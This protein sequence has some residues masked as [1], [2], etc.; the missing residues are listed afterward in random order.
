MLD[1][2]ELPW[3]GLGC[4][5]ARKELSPWLTCARFLILCPRT[6]SC[7]SWRENS[8]SSADCRCYAVRQRP[9]RL[10]GFLGEVFHLRTLQFCFGSVS[11]ET[12]NRLAKVWYLWCDAAKNGVAL[13][14]RRDEEQ[15]V[16]K[17]V[18]CPDVADGFQTHKTT[19]TLGTRDRRTQRRRTMCPGLPLRDW[20]LAMMAEA[21][22]VKELRS[23]SGVVKRPISVLSSKG[24]DLARLAWWPSVKKRMRKV[25][26][27]GERN[28]KQAAM[29]QGVTRQ[30]WF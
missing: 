9:R 27:L 19:L 25:V 24:A 12:M 1:Q 15:I 17:R 14:R 20:L 10:S 22:T 2:C 18:R 4:K 30:R 29:G 6:I 23:V 28:A 13:D 7:G 21:P 3:A 8:H 11:S 26:F 16:V 5:Q